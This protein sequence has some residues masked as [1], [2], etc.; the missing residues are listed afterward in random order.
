MYTKKNLGI[1]L[2]TAI[3]FVQHL[4]FFLLENSATPVHGPYLVLQPS[5]LE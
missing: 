1:L 3:A 4:F 2:S 5:S